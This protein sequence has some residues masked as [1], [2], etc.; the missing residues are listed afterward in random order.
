MYKSL[1]LKPAAP[2]PVAVPAQ[3]KPPKGPSRRI[4]LHGAEHMVGEF[5]ARHAA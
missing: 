1:R 3:V 2:W 5:A 4:F